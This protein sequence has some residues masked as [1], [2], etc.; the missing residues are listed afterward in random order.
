MKTSRLL[1]SVSSKPRSAASRV[2]APATAGIR[3]SSRIQRCARGRIDA[4]ERAGERVAFAHQPVERAGV[5]VGVETDQ[6]V[7]DA[8]HAHLAHRPSLLEHLDLQL[9]ARPDTEDLGELA[10]SAPRLRAAP[11]RRRR[12]RR[13][14]GAARC[15]ARARRAPRDAG[16][17]G[18]ASAPAPRERVRRAAPP[19]TPT[20]RSGRARDADRGTAPSRPR[21]ARRGTGRC[22]GSRS[23]LRSSNRRSGS[24]RRAPCRTPRAPRARAGA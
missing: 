15:P 3:L 21:V 14:C 5:H 8:G 4:Q 20:T 12:R 6:L 10:R 18:S 22:R 17:A 11:A 23:R 1:A 7:R 13:G 2:V 19:A 9:V 16:C 24:R